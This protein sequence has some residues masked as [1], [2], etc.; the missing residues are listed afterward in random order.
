VTFRD[1][2]D[3]REKVAYYLSHDVEREAIAHCAQEYVYQHHTYDQRMARVEA[4]LT[5]L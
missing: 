5:A 1:A 4:L 2:D 3:L